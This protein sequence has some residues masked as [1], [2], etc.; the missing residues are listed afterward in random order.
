MPSINR[1]PKGLQSLLDFKS[2]GKN[3][4]FMDDSIDGSIDLTDFF[5]SDVGLEATFGTQNIDST[6]V[7]TLAATVTVPAGET[8]AIRV[9]Q[10]NCVSAGSQTNIVYPYLPPAISV[11]EV[12]FPMVL[13][14]RVNVVTGAVATMFANDVPVWSCWFERPLV[15]RSGTNLGA[16]VSIMSGITTVACRTEVAYYKLLT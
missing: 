7:G 1:I 12:A 8:W 11:R 15:V 9:V 10:T 14:D 2:L 4:S 3:P 13:V 5:Y 6:D 16:F